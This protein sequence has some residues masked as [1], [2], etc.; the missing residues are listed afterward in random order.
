[1]GETF[2]N[3]KVGY[4][5]VGKNLLISCVLT[6][7]WFAV[8]YHRLIPAILPLPSVHASLTSYLPVPVLNFVE[9]HLGSISMFHKLPSLK[10]IVRLLLVDDLM[11]RIPDDTFYK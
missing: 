3:N 7:P 8:T 5:S 11:K 6:L 2:L 4:G 9:P 1:M 10:S